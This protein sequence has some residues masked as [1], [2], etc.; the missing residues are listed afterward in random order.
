[1][2]FVSQP[3]PPSDLES[4]L[5]YWLR[6]VSNAVSRGFARQVEAEGVTVAEWVF[7]RVLYDSGPI[8]P[9]Q[10]A[11]R[12][13]M[14]RGAVS[15]LAERLVDKGLV[16]RRPNPGDGRAHT[17]VLMPSGRNLVPR[18]AALADGNDAAFF[19]A[20]APPE[21]QQLEQILRKIVRE[22]ALTDIPID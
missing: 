15:K 5:G 11:E 1:V 12:M 4:H 13:A 19:A 17:L 22:R 14:T 2:P 9:S 20:L 8:A 18:L 3:D 21:R 10:L 16:E 6:I 7:L